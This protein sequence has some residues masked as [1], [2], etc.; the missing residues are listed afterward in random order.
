M[1]VVPRLQVMTASK[2]TRRFLGV[3]LFAGITGACAPKNQGPKPI[4]YTIHDRYLAPLERSPKESVFEAY[5]A[6]YVAQSELDHAE[7]SLKDVELEIDIAERDMQSSKLAGA[8]AKILRRSAGATRQKSRDGIAKL[9]ES[10][11]AAEADEATQRLNYLKLEKKH[12]KAK[13]EYSV[14]AIAEAKA[15]FERAKAELAQAEGIEPKGFRVAAF[16]SQDKTR[17]AEAAQR[18]KV[19]VARKSAASKARVVWEKSAGKSTK[20]SVVRLEASNPTSDSLT[21]KIS[22]PAANSQAAPQS[23]TT[24]EEA[25]PPVSAKASEPAQSTSGKTQN[26]E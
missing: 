3:L 20:T 26:S 21:P 12:R 7:F 23:V 14:W 10:G 6:V 19:L 11:A 2:L 1:K 8:N 18:H 17:K 9:A 16:R 13:V 22:P 4:K 5:K 24:P 25:L 15:S